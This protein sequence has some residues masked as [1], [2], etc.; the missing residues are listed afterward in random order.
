MGS[1]SV[2]NRDDPRARALLRLC[3]ML[4]CG[5]FVVE[6]IAYLCLREHLGEGDIL[7]VLDG[8]QRL[9]ALGRNNLVVGAAAGLL[10]HAGMAALLSLALQLTWLR[11]RSLALSIVLLIFVAFQGSVV[12]LAVGNY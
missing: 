9:F 5:F 12:A 6:M 8:R 11:S 10:I 4:S 2:I 1:P 3:L 7:R